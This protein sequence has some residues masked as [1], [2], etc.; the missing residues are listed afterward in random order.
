MIDPNTMTDTGK[1]KKIIYLDKLKGDRHSLL[2]EITNQGYIYAELHE[3]FPA[4]DLVDPELFPSLLYYYG[5]LTIVG[6]K[7][8][9]VKLGIPNENVRRQ[10]E[11]E[12]IHSE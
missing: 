12:S 8:R 4:Q 9:R 6:R 7:G 3:S 11:A 1:L 5:L 2:R 10:L